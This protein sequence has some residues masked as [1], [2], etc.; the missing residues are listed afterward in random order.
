MNKVGI[1]TFQNS[2]N[3]GALLQTFATHSFL[4]QQK[5]ETTVIDY[6]SPNKTNV[7]KIIQFDKN[8]VVGT[9]KSLT[10]IPERLGK[11]FISEQFRK[12]SLRLTENVIKDKEGLFECTK[13]FSQIIVGSDQVWNYENTK[14]DT[15]YLLDFV[16]DG[17]TK[18]S[19]AASFGKD[20][21]SEEVP[22]S[23][24]ECN[25]YITS[26][27]EE[28]KKYLSRFDFIST[29][30]ISGKKIVEDILGQECPV[31]LDPTLLFGKT[32]WLRA[33]KVSKSP[34]KRKYLL[35]YSLDN[36]PEMYEIANKI[37][38][39]NGWEVRQIF[40]HPR[41]LKYKVKNTKPS[42]LGF[43]QEIA[44]AEYILTDSFHGTAFSIN[45]EKQFNVFYHP[46]KNSYTR[47]DNLLEI[48]GLENKKVFSQND[49]DQSTIDYDEVSTKIAPHRNYSQKFL[50]DAVGSN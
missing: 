28:Y 10:R 23:V 16:P 35:I 39:K 31:V 27:R 45:L 17:T 24:K 7:Y 21:I 47:I 18:I 5:I 8:S 12:E 38:T 37:A 40:R 20:S 36:K 14:F 9:I 43:V 41:G 4:T 29:R 34:S 26:L 3:Y 19:Y 49:I 44:N 11:R 6:F 50:L 15:S 1:L 42:I 30:E 33:S 48:V 2:D 32:E 46:E 13:D 25:P 22:R